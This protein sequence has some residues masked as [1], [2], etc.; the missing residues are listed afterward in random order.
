MTYGRRRRLATFRLSHSEPGPIQKLNPQERTNSLISLGNI[1][2]LRHMLFGYFG[3][4]YLSSKYPKAELLL[5]KLI[6]S[7]LFAREVLLVKKVG[8]SK[9]LRPPSI[10]LLK[11]I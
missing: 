1:H 11:L 9:K 4:T 10:Q 5:L 7:D 2:I 3:P 6:H 8:K